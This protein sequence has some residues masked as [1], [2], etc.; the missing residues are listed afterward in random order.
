MSKA[1]SDRSDF[2][3]SSMLPYELQDCKDLDVPLQEDASV[4]DSSSKVNDAEDVEPEPQVENLAGVNLVVDNSSTS[5]DDSLLQE[6]NVVEDRTD[7]GSADIVADSNVES[8]PQDDEDMLSMVSNTDRNNDIYDF[9]EDVIS[10]DDSSSKIKE[11]DPPHQD[12]VIVEDVTDEDEVIEPSDTRMSEN[13][14]P[15][16]DIQEPEEPR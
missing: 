8:V 2:E 1:L 9:G 13:K 5:D 11:D 12:R 6:V 10:S 4:S 16:E 15:S 14:R 7:I 3:L